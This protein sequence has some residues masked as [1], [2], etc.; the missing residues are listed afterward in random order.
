MSSTLVDSIDETVSEVL[1]AGVLQAFYAHLAANGIAREDIPIK[2][3]R[4]CFILDKSFGLAGTTLQRAIAK[5]LYVKLFLT[6]VPS[7]S[8]TLEGYFEEAANKIED[9]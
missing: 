1:G 8:K 9:K 6:F 3:R 2:L 4:F 5:H 7:D